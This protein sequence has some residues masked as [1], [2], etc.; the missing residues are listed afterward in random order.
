MKSAN[1]RWRR[2]GLIIEPPTSGDY[3]W[4]VDCAGIP[5]CMP[6]SDN[7]WRI[8]FAGVNIRGQR[9]ILC[10]D[11]D[12]GHG[13]KIL[14]IRECPGLERGT[15]DAFDSA[16]LW[17]CSVMRVEGRIF[18]WYTGMRLVRDVPFQNAIGLA[19]SEDDGF[20]FKK[21]SSNPILPAGHEETDFVT[22]P[23]VE[24]LDEKFVMF[25]SECTKWE[26]IAGR[27]ESFYD[28]RVAY[29]SDGINWTK[30]K[31]PVISLD[32]TPWAGIVRPWVD[33]SGKHR[34]WWS[35]RGATD[36]RNAS[37]QAYRLYSAPVSG[38]DIDKSAIEQVNFVPAPENDEW[39]SWMQA[40][41]SLVPY[42]GKLVLLYTG[43]NFGRQGFGYALS[44]P[45]F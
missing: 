1:T 12:P 2:M 30:R 21:V 15:S 19:V 3:E 26:H 28:L 23:F 6:F 22:S 20:T 34:M 25:Y 24:R 39:D 42:Q 29:S 38:V 41:C 27:L 45:E 5:T 11:I 40:Y 33:R 14:E 7:L 17:P 4:W 8:W 44:E 18:L 31:N 9:G 32:G 36:F 35:A 13:M 16:G 43:N 10:A 37:E